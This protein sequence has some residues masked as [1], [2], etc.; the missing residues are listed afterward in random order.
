[1]HELSFPLANYY[2][3]QTIMDYDVKV[4]PI[5]HASSIIFEHQRI[6]TLL[7]KRDRKVIFN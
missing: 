4:T 3:P 5:C 2:H 6:V 1:M 7:D